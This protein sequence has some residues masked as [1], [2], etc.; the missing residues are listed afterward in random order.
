M[1]TSGLHMSIQ[2]FAKCLMEHAIVGKI[3]WGSL[4]RPKRQSG[5]LG[6]AWRAHHLG[7]ASIIQAICFK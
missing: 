7:P 5:V 6:V 1:E 4:E 3:C 2:S